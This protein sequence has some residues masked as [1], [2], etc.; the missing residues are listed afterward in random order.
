MYYPTVKSHQIAIR[1][2]YNESFVNAQTAAELNITMTTRCAGLSLPKSIID[3][4]QVN[5]GSLLEGIINYF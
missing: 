1:N 4:I 2:R 5:L 3:Y